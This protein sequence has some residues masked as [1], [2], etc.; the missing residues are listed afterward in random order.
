MGDVERHEQRIVVQPVA[1]SVT[2]AF[3]SQ[4]LTNALV[5]EEVFGGASQVGNP[6]AP[7]RVVIDSSFRKSG[8]R[9]EAGCAEPAGVAQLAQIDQQ[10][11]AGKS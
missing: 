6:E 7:Y 10:F 3:E 5:A 4:A 1:R 2:E 8:N 9:I 11:I